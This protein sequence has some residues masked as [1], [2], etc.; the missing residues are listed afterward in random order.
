MPIQPLYHIRE[1]GHPDVPHIHRVMASQAEYSLRVTATPPS[2]ADA[3]ACLTEVPDGHSPDDLQVLGVFD[4]ATLVGF[5]VVLKHFP[6]PGKAHIALL[7]VHAD[8]EGQGLANAL[9][10]E[11][12][13]RLKDEGDITATRLN[14][15]ATNST[16]VPFWERL[17]YR[18]TEPPR[19]YIAGSVQT[20]VHTFERPLV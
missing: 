7:M 18:E 10:N 14:V 11:L 19:P 3:E 16:V 15:V 6:T 9:H 1:L 2:A 20:Y 17:G 12:I 5:T 8:Y 4:E 13:C